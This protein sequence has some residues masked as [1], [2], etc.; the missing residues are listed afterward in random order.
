M[1]MNGGGAGTPPVTER[2]RIGLVIG[3]AL[4]VAGLVFVGAVLPAEY[5]IDPL[6]TG[7]LLGLTPLGDLQQQ[8]AAF[9]TAR[10]GE[11]PGAPTIAA[12]DRRFAEETRTFT[13]EPR[14]FVEYK[15][16]LDKGQA[17][18]FTLTASAAVNVEFHAEPDGAPAGFAETYEK[19]SA[20][21]TAS[22]TLTAPFAGIH[23]WYWENTTDAPATVTLASA[24]FYRLSHEFRKDQPTITKTFQPR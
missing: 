17:L 13:L 4:L 3:V 22:G 12:A 5:S 14:G 8:L 20:I 10:A 1:T 2:E 18:L 9:E 24:G 7:R 23:G 16:R 6:G 19:K 21:T 15:Y 11:A